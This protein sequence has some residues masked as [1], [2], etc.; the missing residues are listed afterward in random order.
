MTFFSSLC[1][2]GQLCAPAAA[3]TFSHLW[4]LW[5]WR[6]PFPQRQRIRSTHCMSAKEIKPNVFYSSSQHNRSQMIV[7]L[8]RWIV[9]V[10][11]WILENNLAPR[12]SNQP[13]PAHFH[14]AG[15]DSSY[16]A[17]GTETNTNLDALLPED[18]TL[19]FTAFHRVT[20]SPKRS[21][22]QT[23]S[24]AA[25]HLI[26]SSGGPQQTGLSRPVRKTNGPKSN[27]WAIHYP[28]PDPPSSLAPPK[29]HINLKKVTHFSP[30][31]SSHCPTVPLVL[32]NLSTV[33][34]K[35]GVNTAVS[36]HQ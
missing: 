6:Q 22:R 33:H 28:A 25:P 8:M 18:G 15:T 14:S 16:W 3:A 9:S 19:V 20:E 24:C 4:I 2:S 17:W 35:A 29:L 31:I 5:T 10:V 11:K 34:G 26:L 7:K 21:W 36:L 23:W 12:C 13:G 1:S 27:A 32:I 30:T